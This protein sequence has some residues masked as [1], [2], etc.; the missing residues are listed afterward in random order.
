MA[1]EKLAKAGT[2]AGQLK[3]NINL[4][5]SRIAVSEFQLIPS[6][7]AIQCLIAGSNDRAKAIATKLQEAGLDVRPILSPTVPKGSERIRICLHAF[8]T[9]DEIALLA[10]TINTY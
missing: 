9:P 3:N 7:S 6:D 4:F 5:K 2:E 10:D 8:N 1:Y